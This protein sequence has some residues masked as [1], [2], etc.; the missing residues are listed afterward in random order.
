MNNKM[1]EE[2]CWIYQYRISDCGHFY[3][4]FGIWSG[5]DY[6]MKNIDD[7]FNKQW[8]VSVQRERHA[9]LTKRFNGGM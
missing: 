9:E 7:V 3:R 4:P 1:F 8:N 5:G 6:Y 2:D